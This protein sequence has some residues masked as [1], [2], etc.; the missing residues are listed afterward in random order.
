MHGLSHRC[1]GSLA[2]HFSTDARAA[3]GRDRPAAPDPPVRTAHGP[4]SSVA[5][6]GTGPGPDCPGN[7]MGRLQG[8]MAFSGCRVSDDTKFLRLDDEFRGVLGLKLGG[9]AHTVPFDS[10]FSEIEFRGY[11]LV[12]ETF[13]HESE[14]VTFTVG[15]FG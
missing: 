7:G 15:E 1:Q 8:A 14:N 12:R 2:V 6:G 3:R 10:L 13:G 4:P 5:A 11:F 9:Q